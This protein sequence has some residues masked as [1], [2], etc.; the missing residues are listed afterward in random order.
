MARWSRMLPVLVLIASLPVLAAGH[1]NEQ[2]GV[3]RIMRQKLQHS[4]KVLEGVAEADFDVI[5]SNAN[6]L[7]ALSNLAEWRVLK[8]PMY[9]LLSNEF[10]R[11]AENLVRTS[12]DKNLDGA[13]LAYV[14]LTLTCVKCHKHIRE[15]RMSRRGDGDRR[16]IAG[17]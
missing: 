17:R 7:I 10:R 13:A 3:R 15:V 12:K 5:I 6:D 9:E 8:T 1:S 16:I 11:S 4:Q 14:D 2:A